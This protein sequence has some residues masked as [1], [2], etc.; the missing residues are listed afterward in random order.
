[1]T[2]LIL[3]LEYVGKHWKQLSTAAVTFAG[4]VQAVL[5]AFGHPGG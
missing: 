5:A 3:I 4:L 1:M 2:R